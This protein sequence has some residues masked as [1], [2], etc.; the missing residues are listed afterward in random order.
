MDQNSIRDARYDPKS[1][2]TKVK[3]GGWDYVQK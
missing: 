3:R 2:P 1:E